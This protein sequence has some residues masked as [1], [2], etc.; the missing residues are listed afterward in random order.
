MRIIL[1]SSSNALR[2]HKFIVLHSTSSSSILDPGAPMP[3]FPLGPPAPIPGG[4]AAPPP[5]GPSPGMEE[6][7]WLRT[8]CCATSRFC[9]NKDS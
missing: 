8:L 1:F 4:P 2:V 9:K 5:E 3:A 6:T 7:A